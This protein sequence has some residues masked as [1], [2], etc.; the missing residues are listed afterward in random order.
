MA[1]APGAGRVSQGAPR[2]H[3]APAGGSAAGTLDPQINYTLQYWQLYQPIY[4]G[5][6]DLQEAAGTEGFN[7][8]PDLAEAMPEAEQ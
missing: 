1:A 3:D 8:V 2:R 5:L 7:I 6:V 4:D